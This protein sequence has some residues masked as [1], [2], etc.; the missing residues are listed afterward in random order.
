MLDCCLSG[1]GD[2]ETA[3]G[4]FIACFFDNVVLLAGDEGFIDFDGAR[5]YDAVIH[6]LVAEA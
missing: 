4:E 3:R 6:Y 2:Y 1:A 5:L